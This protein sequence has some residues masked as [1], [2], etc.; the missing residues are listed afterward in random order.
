M[1][2]L[3]SAIEGFRDEIEA[4]LRASI[5]ED[6]DTGPEDAAP[7]AASDRS[8]SRLYGMVRYHLGWSDTDL[9]PTR[10]PAGKRLRPVLCLLAA[11]GV[12]ADHRRA[13]PGA[14]AIELIHNFSL[15]HDDIMDRSDERHHRRTVWRQWGEAQAIDVG[16]AILILA[17]LTLLRAADRGVSARSVLDGVA[18]LNRASLRLAE[19]QHLDLGF[20]GK[21]DVSA[22]AYFAMISGKTAALVAGSLGLGALL[23]SEDP[24]L[25][26]RYAEVGEELGLAF[27][28]QDDV[29]GI[30]GEP[31]RTGKP[32]AADVYQRKMTLPVIHAL[33]TADRAGARELGS[34]Y[35]ASPSP[36][37][38]AQADRALEILEAAGAREHA[39]RIAEA[40]Y[41][42]A[43]ALLEA[44]HPADD[45]GRNLRAIAAFLLQRDY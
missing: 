34:I 21:L 9:R 40:H 10:A 26:S 38:T 41:T 30:W 27:Q 37:T 6:A 4:E 5:P 14:A 29:L 25:A 35:A 7:G 3:P 39:A 45:A 13:L 28:I 8:A 17:E 23:G 44:L 24:T 18:L 11:E 15:V 2:E 19:G 20:E 33:A 12:G 43:L 32:G 36:V 22:E 16:D 42:R 1:P 31:A